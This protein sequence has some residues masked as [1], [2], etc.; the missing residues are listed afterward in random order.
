MKSPLLMCV[1]ISSLLF[2]N[3]SRANPG[4]VDD[5]YWI[6]IAIKQLEELRNQYRVLSETYENAKS[7]LN[8][9]NQLKTMNS[10]HY[11]FGNLQN[12]TDAL[13]NWQSPA[14][15]WQDALQNLSGGNNARYQALMQAYEK[16]HPILNEAQFAKNA[17]PE[18]TA[19]FKEDKAVNRAVNVQTT[20]SYDEI[21]QRMKALYRLSQQIEKAPNTKGAVDLNSR[22]VTELAFIQLMSLRLQTLMNQQASQESLS[23][24]Q[25]RAELARFNKLKLN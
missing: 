18:L 16:N 5:S 11:G 2:S 14:N 24:L 23:E 22:L 12:G 19:R 13:Q 6:W 25:D 20:Q 8:S 21:N 3:I 7:Q 10:G 17:T 1:L 4:V 9:L 15:T